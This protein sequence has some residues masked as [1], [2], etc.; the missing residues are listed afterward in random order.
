MY[1]STLLPHRD[2]PLGTPLRALPRSNYPIAIIGVPFSGP[3]DGGC[4]P[5]KVRHLLT[6]VPQFLAMSGILSSS[7]S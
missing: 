2:Y 4:S 6:L 5:E 7:P 1:P 3:P